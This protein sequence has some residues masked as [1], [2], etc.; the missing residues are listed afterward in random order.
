[1]IEYLERIYGE[2]LEQY[3]KELARSLENG[4]KQFVVTVNPEILMT[5][6]SDE[7]VDKMLLDQRVTLIPDGISVVKA[8]QM[9]NIPVTERMAGVELAEFLI[10][11]AHLQKKSVYLFGAKSDVVLALKE[12][13]EKE[14]PNAYVC[15][16]CDGY[17]QD[18]DSVFD[19]I[20]EM[21]PDVA[22]I[23]LGVPMQEKL[24]Y[25]HFDRFDKGIFIGVGGSFDVL[26]GTKKRAPEFFIKHNIEWLYRI[27]KEPKRLKRF[28]NNNI[29]FIQ[30][31]RK[32]K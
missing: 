28:Y 1:M 11:E 3:H 6:P 30:K 24:I 16:I 15:G 20:A 13:I 10:K 25:K 14:Y 31:I 2:S 18:K 26:S 32:E 23:A 27:A 8:C 12:K 19:E 17:R 9:K 7:S 4:E 5:A 22:L 29:K 21:K